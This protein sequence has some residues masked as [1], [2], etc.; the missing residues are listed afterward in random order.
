[1]N[2]KYSLA[3]LSIISCVAHFA[4]AA[5]TTGADMVLTSAAPLA[6]KSAS[7]INVVRGEVTPAQLNPVQIVPPTGR[8]REQVI[9][10]LLLAK[11]D[12]SYMSPSEISPS[13]P[14]KR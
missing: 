4:C 2:T 6:E 3:L 14:A 1:M 10:E 12:G 5:E 13:A 9:N 11:Q 8:T 7:D